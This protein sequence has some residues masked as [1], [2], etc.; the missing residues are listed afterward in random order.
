MKIVDLKVK[1]GDGIKNGDYSPI[2]SAEVTISGVVDEND[3]PEAALDRLAIVAKRK[4]NR[5]LV[6]QDAPGEAVDGLTLAAGEAVETQMADAEVDR[7]A[8]KAAL[9]RKRSKTPLEPR[10]GQQAREERNAAAK[11][12]EEAVNPEPVAE[13]VVEPEPPK[14][15]TNAQLSDA[16]AKKAQE[17]GAPA[18]P[19]LVK[20]L[21]F[22]FNP[23]PGQPF[24]SAQMPKEKRQEFLTKLEELKA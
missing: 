6:A 21:V 20:A 4:V 10:L 24:H 22:S 2:R 16:C 5:M 9:A 19:K 13:A 14:D 15:I 12:A 17:I 18:G 8:K 7:A 1:F 3:D 11:A 23:N